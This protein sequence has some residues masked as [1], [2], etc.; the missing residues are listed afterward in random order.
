MALIRA[1]P[2]VRALKSVWGWSV[3]TSY[4][5][6]PVAPGCQAVEQL[7]QCWVFFFLPCCCSVDLFKLELKG[8]RSPGERFVAGRPSCAARPPH[9]APAARVPENCRQIQTTKQLGRLQSH[10]VPLLPGFAVKRDLAVTAWPPRAGGWVPSQAGGWGVAQQSWQHMS[11]L[12]GSRL[13][14]GQTSPA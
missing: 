13:K 6:L 5:T 1:W 9:T 7:E 3:D 4:N 8:W 12:V 14:Q 11:G 10:A 2:F